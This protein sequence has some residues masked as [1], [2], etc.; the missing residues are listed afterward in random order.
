MRIMDAQYDW[1][2]GSSKLRQA[3][4][5]ILFIG[6]PKNDSIA[7]TLQSGRVIQIDSWGGQQKEYIV[8]E[9]MAACVGETLSGTNIGITQENQL[10]ISPST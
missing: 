6:R 2:I 7:I 8:T 10:M 4:E 1:I 9:K 3:N 5:D